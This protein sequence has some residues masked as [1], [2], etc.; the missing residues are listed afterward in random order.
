MFYA[1]ALCSCTNHSSDDGYTAYIPPSVPVI[2]Y[3]V[4]KIIPHDISL[5]T[6]GLLIHDGKFFESTGSPQELP[7]TKSMI[8]IIDTAT[9]KMDTKVFLDKKY[10]GE[11]IVFIKNKLYQVT[12]Q[13]KTGFV[14]DDK[15][16]RLQRT[17]SYLNKEG[18]GL[19]TD[20]KAI[21]MTDGTDALTF[22]NPANLEQQRVLKVTENGLP[23]DSLN[24]PEYI[25]GFIY[26]NIWM[27]NKIVK[28]DAATGKVVACLEC[29]SLVLEARRNNPG[30]DVLNGIAY[31]SLTDKIY[32]TGKL[33]PA[34][35]EIGFMH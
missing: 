21:I 1:M 2:T 33:W 27:N 20:G 18:W 4:N 17:F 9:G 24:E 12:Y 16:Y 28:I 10:F 15:N 32:V 5:F 8:G 3:T 19:T 35:Y 6:E 11:G 26:A 30:A 23:R 14:Y 22:L 29:S 13:N 7:Q 31:D 25:K 34:I